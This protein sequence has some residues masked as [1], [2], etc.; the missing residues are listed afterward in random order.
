MP[1]KA[2]TRSTLSWPA[3][4]QISSCRCREPHPSSSGDEPVLVDES[5]KDVGSSYASEVGIGDRGGRF[6][7]H[8]GAPLIEGSVRPVPVVVIHVLGEGTVRTDERE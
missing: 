7:D 8:R 5:A 3:A 2:G 4:E 6:G 1:R